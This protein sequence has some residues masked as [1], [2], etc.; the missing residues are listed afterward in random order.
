MTFINTQRGDIVE[1]WKGRSSLHDAEQLHRERRAN[2][3]P[4]VL[5]N[6]FAE[7]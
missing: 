2:L 6:M 4:F 7:S 1:S 3:G 5:T